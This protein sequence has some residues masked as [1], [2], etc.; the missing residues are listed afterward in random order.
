V[1][2]RFS[3]AFLTEAVRPANLPFGGLLIFFILLTTNRV[4][5]VVYK[6]NYQEVK[7]L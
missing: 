3:P 1:S 7:K 5:K 6:K 2:E 4:I